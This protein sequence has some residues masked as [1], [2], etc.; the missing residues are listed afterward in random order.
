MSGSPAIGDGR[1]AS[2]SFDGRASMNCPIMLI[3]IDVS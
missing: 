3:E 2:S 1:V